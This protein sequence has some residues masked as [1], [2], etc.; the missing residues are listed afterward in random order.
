VP[1]EDDRCWN[2][3]SY[4]DA[5]AIGKAKQVG[6]WSQ[7]ELERSWEFYPHLWEHLWQMIL[8]HRRF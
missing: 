3:R 6:F 1:V 2:S 8:M 5:E 4:G 7:Q